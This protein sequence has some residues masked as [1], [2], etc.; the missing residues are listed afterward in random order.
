MR[1]LNGGCHSHAVNSLK[2]GLGRHHER[3]MRV[4][5]NLPEVQTWSHSHECP[6]AYG[7]RGNVIGAANRDG[8]V[9]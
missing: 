4:V 7:E 9:E 3:A 5:R 8:V 2:S 6:A 1:Q